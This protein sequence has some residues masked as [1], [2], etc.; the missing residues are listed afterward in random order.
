MN[1]THGSHTP[2]LPGDTEVSA[3]V[4]AHCRAVSFLNSPIHHTP[5]VIVCIYFYSAFMAL[6]IGQETGNGMGGVTCSK[7]PQVAHCMGHMLYQP[8]ETLVFFILCCIIY[9]SIMNSV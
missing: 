1:N 8:R 7:G 6:V 2:L 4:L 9:S 5:F 3:A